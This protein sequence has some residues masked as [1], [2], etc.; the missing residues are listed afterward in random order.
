MYLVLQ[1]EKPSPKGKRTARIH[2]PPTFAEGVPN[3]DI[4]LMSEKIQNIKEKSFDIMTCPS[5]P[6]IMLT[7][8]GFNLLLLWTISSGTISVPQTPG[9]ILLN[10]Y[11][12][13]LLFKN[14]LLKWTNSEDWKHWSKRKALWWYRT[15]FSRCI[16]HQHFEEYQI[17]TKY[18]RKPLL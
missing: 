18:I 2:D 4:H 17:F 14:Y 6:I 16:V 7:F 5:V 9:F 1:K 8:G 15:L 3:T 12:L 10:L 11:I 13:F